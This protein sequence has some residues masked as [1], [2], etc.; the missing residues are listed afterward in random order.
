MPKFVSAMVQTRARWRLQADRIAKCEIA[1]WT[2]AIW[3][4]H[5]GTAFLVLKWE[6]SLFCRLG[7]PKKIAK[8]SSEMD[9]GK[10]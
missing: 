10:I 2:N 1:C 9:E 3:T 7:N 8:M 4:S 6:T 5:A